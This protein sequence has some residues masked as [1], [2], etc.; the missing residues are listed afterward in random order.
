[1]STSENSA[2][3][4]DEIAS[5]LRQ[6]ILSGR[7]EAGTRITELELSKRFQTGRGIVRE[8]VQRLSV[9]GLMKSKPNCGAIVAPEAPKL[10][11]NLIVPIRRT[12]EAFALEQVFDSLTIDDYHVW[13]DIIERMRDACKT[14]DHHELAELDIAFHRYLIDRADLPDLIAIW[15][16]LVGR[17]RSHFRRVQRRFENLNVIPEEHE[18]LLNA[19]RGSDLSAAIRLLKEKID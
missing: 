12:V 17:I 11:R 15:E 14:S 13:Q 9:Q 1:M 16:S 19:F 3:A 4:A 10:I 2:T 8:A 7:L 5:Q 6:E 18:S